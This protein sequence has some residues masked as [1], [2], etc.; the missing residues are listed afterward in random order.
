M[1]S[2]IACGVMLLRPAKKISETLKTTYGHEK[3][4]FIVFE[5]YEHLFTL[6]QGDSS[7]QDHYTILRGLLDELDVYPSLV[8][9]ISKIR[10]YRDELAVVVYLSNLKL[11]C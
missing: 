3:N 2:S 4:I 1:E 5:I 10:Q 8:A 11:S 7:V 6:C 9:D